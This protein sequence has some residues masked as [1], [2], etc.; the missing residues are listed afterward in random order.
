[1]LKI[2]AGKFYRT[3]SGR[4]VFVGAV[5]LPGPWGDRLNYPVKGWIQGNATML[6]WRECGAFSSA[7]RPDYNDLVEEWREPTSLMAYLRRTKAGHLYV[8]E[9]DGGL[10]G[11][12][13]IGSARVVEGVFAE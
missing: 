1:M 9:V 13:T 2:E 3:R 10:E 6:A 8:S 5:F 4:K 11:S 12:A 7:D